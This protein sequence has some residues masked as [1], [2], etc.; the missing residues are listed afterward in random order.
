MYGPTK[1]KDDRNS[2]H[3][4]FLDVMSKFSSGNDYYMGSNVPKLYYEVD[5]A[6]NNYKDYMRVFNAVSDALSGARTA[7]S[8]LPILYLY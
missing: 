4:F 1:P 3:K 2:I 8:F 5:K 6:N 7:G